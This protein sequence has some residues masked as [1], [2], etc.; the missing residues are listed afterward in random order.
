VKTYQVIWRL[1]RFSPASF[2]AALLC[3][4]AVFGLPVPLGL[5]TLTFFD[6]L[7]GAATVRNGVGAVI[8]LFVV[9]EAFGVLSNAGLSLSWGSLLQTSMALLRKNLLRAVLQA[10]AAVALAESSGAAMSRFRDDVEEVVESIDAW[11]DLA[12]RSITVVA[13]LVIM[14]RI[15]ATITAFAFLPLAAV[16][17][18]VNQAQG[19]IAAYR[20][21]S[22]QA[23]GRATSFLADLLGAVQAVKVAGATPHV[24]AHLGALNEQR[25][26]TDLRDQVFSGLLDGFNVNV[27][28]LGTGVVLLVA[29]RALRAGSFTV[30]DFALFVTYLNALTWFGDEISRWFLGYQQ[31]GVSMGRLA[32]LVPFAAPDALVASMPIVAGAAPVGELLPPARS[33]A[34]GLETLDIAGLTYLHPSSRRGISDVD[35]HLARGEFVVITGRVGAGKS[36]LL[37]ALLGLLP[38]DSGDIRWNGETVSNPREFFR[39]PRAAY[40]P[41]TPRLFSE[42]LQDNILLGLRADPARLQRAVRAA[43]LERDV[44]GLEQG[45]QTVVGPRG[46]RLSGGQVQRAAASRMFVREAEL[47][48]IDDLSSALDG[49]TERLLWERLFARREATCL[50]VSHRR[51]ALRTADRVVVLAAGRVMAQ[52]TLAELLETSEE[53]RRLWAG[54]VS[55]PS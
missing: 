55:W 22:R 44:T 19:P 17:I 51:A 21:R 50:V 18:A 16:V 7:N 33:G 11:L 24:V 32:A 48:V 42:S 28:N 13:A 12:G 15:N 38:A 46:V 52:G 43:V 20:L 9:T 34:D 30:G 4:V 49:D 5:V 37:Q 10:P 31:T 3:S 45:L 40:T 6:R 27:V 23:L 54:E 2:S 35:L 8:A 14:L 47:L 53:M 26:R 41:Q 1:I 29:A 39:P 36:T 25:R